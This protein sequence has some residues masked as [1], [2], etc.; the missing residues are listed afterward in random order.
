MIVAVGWLCFILTL[1]AVS[2]DAPPNI[3]LVLSDDHRADL[4]GC[5][6]HPIV[7]TPHIDRLTERGVRYANAFVTTSIC[8]ASRATILT[9]LVERTHGFTF[10]TP[11][12]ARKLCER[13]YPFVLRANGYRTGLVGKFGVTVEGGSATL[14]TLFDSF[15]PLERTPYLKQL[16]DGQT[17]H[18][19]DQS[20]DKAIE[21]LR[22]N[23]PGQ[24]FCLSLSFNAAHAEDDDLEE[25]YPFP[26][27][28]AEL[29]TDLE[30]P[31][32]RLDGAEVYESQPDFLKES[33]N[34]QRFFW[35]WDSPEKYQ[36]N[37][38]NYLRML[39]G[40]DRN[41]GRVLEELEAL[42]LADHTL[43]IFM[44]DNGY[45]LG[46]RGFAGKW[47]SYDESLRVPL[48][49]HDPRLP[50]ELR[51][52]VPLHI[53]LNLDIAATIL[54]AAGLPPDEHA[55][56]HS[57]LPGVFGAAWAYRRERF[58]CEHLMVHPEIP[59]WQGI[60]T[61]RFKYANYLD[62][63]APAE[64]LHDLVAD[65]D[66]LVNLAGR[67]EYGAVLEALRSECEQQAAFY[68]Q[69]RSALLSPTPHIL[70]LGDSI[71]MG[72]HPYVVQAL[73]SEARVVRPDENCAGTTKGVSKIDQWLALDGGAFDIIHFNFGLHDLKRVTR[74]GSNSNDPDDPP[75]AD[76]A[77]Y[78]RNLRQIVEALETTDAALI[79]ATTTPVPPGVRPHRDQ[80]DPERYNQVARRIMQEHGI[81][82]DD[83]Y[84][85][86]LAQPAE[87]Q[88]PADV[89]FTPDGSQLLATEVV[90]QL[91][92]ALERERA[93]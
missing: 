48:V 5:A 16:P 88:R 76:L 92:R 73:G 15:V 38:R 26:P 59:R 43:V 89:H 91:R 32:P 52:R 41:I 93:K 71:S 36:R 55:Q 57:L 54:D 47:S 22:S 20:G 83:L 82:L 10:G 51:G 65:P 74:T 75:Q 58:F 11:P 7:K 85:F 35:R 61:E 67:D 21:F 50:E 14:A 39:S 81:A 18:L 33:L 42:H 70:L 2:R 49:I 25:Q 17:R 40:I 56:G 34:R 31:R 69:A 13:S 66:E 78:E 46:E 90:R 27:D 9:G 1:A 62:A 6:G 30:L 8:A 64:W 37:L 87:I 60:R 68:E 23:P 84:T 63:P 4:L 77:A 72:Y 28:E 3:V 29:Y 19:T 53:A 80:Q 79:F 44:G 45:Y 24:P 12:L 86:A